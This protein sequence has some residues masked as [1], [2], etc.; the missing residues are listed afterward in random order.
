MPKLLKH[1]S[2]Y[3]D[4][5]TFEYRYDGEELVYL[6]KL[7]PGSVQHSEANHIA[8]QAGMDTKILERSEA[9]LESFSKGIPIRMNS[10]KKVD[11]E[12]LTKASEEFLNLE[13]DPD[14]LNEMFGKMV[15]LMKQI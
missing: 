14:N 2:I 13:L 1:L 10:L 8:K 6:Y 5:A 12:N 11:V 4:Y 15:E 9:I 7:K 3:I